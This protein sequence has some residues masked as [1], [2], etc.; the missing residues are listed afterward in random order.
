MDSDPAAAAPN[1]GMEA[2]FGMP[3]MP[4]PAAA[5][6]VGGM[7]PA[8]DGG[9]GGNAEGAAP[10]MPTMPNPMM[11]MMAP[12]GMSG[13]PTMP[14]M[15]NPMMMNPMMAM[16]PMAMMMGNPMMAQVNPMMQ[17]MLATTAAAAESSGNQPAGSNIEEANPIH[18]EVLQLCNDFRVEER[19]M[20][21]LNRILERRPETFADDIR[22]LRERLSM[23]RAEIGVL[24]MQLERSSFVNNSS[25]GGDIQGIV[26]KYQ[27]DHRAKERLVESM[28]NRK[29]TR[30]QDLANI[31]ER[32]ADAANPSSLLM[33]LLQTLDTTGRLPIKPG[34]TAK[35]TIQKERSMKEAEE[36]RER[37]ERERQEREAKREAKRKKK[38]RSRS[39]SRSSKSKKSKTKKKSRSRG[40]RRR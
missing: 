26:E 28:Y 6:S 21:K 22:T 11:A 24:M 25:V 38:S 4:Y 15:M 19:L 2:A 8:A 1:A 9:M 32:L 10:C 37:E 20:K 30:T 23:P 39:R 31:E 7:V 27:L 33:K 3:C 35:M 12:M 17:Q 34:S 40:R 18:P 13:M 36:R 29:E 16:N 5:T 14:T